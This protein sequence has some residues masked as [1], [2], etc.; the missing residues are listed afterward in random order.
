M[1]RRLAQNLALL[2]KKCRR[3]YLM[4]SYREQKNTVAWRKGLEEYEK[5]LEEVWFYSGI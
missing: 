2:S 4:D 3:V 5:E 1:L